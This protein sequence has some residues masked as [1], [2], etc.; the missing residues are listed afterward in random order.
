MVYISQIF[1]VEIKQ[2]FQQI[3][4]NVKLMQDRGCSACGDAKFSYSQ[5]AVCQ[6]V[7]AAIVRKVSANPLLCLHGNVPDCLKQNEEVAPL[8][9]VPAR[10]AIVVKWVRDDPPCCSTWNS[11]ISEV[12][13]TV[14]DGRAYDLLQK[15]K[16]QLK[17]LEVKYNLDLSGR[18]LWTKDRSGD[19]WHELDPCTQQLSFN[20]SILC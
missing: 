1:T 8:L 17:S 20:I 11:M 7:N 14:I 2:E 16:E 10:K 19:I 18:Q 15:W 6:N 13:R 5:S 4:P 9:I 3:V 12:D